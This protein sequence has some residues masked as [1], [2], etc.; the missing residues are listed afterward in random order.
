MPVEPDL[1]RLLNMQA[2]VTGLE[3]ATLLRCES[4]AAPVLAAP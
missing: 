4:G 2:L 1:E 3:M